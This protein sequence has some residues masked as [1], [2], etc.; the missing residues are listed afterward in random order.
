ME[1]RILIDLLVQLGAC[2]EARETA[3]HTVHHHTDREQHLR[4]LQAEYEEDAA[5]AA[6]GERTVAV[7]LRLKEAEIR[8]AAAA[9]ALKNDR[10]V[11]LSDRRQFQALQLEI[12]GLE[13]KLA[14]LES[15]ALLLVEAEDAA[16]AATGDARGD[17]ARQAGRGE[18]EAVRLHAESEAA[19]RAGADHE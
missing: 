19:A 8:T 4:E 11:G 1:E 12:A 5:E 3:A 13:Q 6:D 2:E 7:R 17:A 15:E 18:R 16:R 9:L 10:I 14:D